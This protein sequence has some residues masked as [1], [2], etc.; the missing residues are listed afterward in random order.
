MPSC[1]ASTATCLRASRTPRTVR[2]SPPSPT[3][4]DASCSLGSSPHLHPSHPPPVPV[5]T[6]HHRLLPAPDDGL[7]P[8]PSRPHA[9]LLQVTDR[10]PRVYLDGCVVVSC[11]SLSHPPPRPRRLTFATQ[12]RPRLRL[13]RALAR[14][15]RVDGRVPR[16][17]RHPPLRAQLGRLSLLRVPADARGSVHVQADVLG[18]VHH[19]GASSSPRLR[20]RHFPVEIA[21]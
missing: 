21:R 17:A 14:A 12:R 8:P 2:P 10:A 7:R 3:F 13:L 6:R 11:P 18:L 4:L 16:L 20:P 9:R 19:L 1:L 5:H 15:K